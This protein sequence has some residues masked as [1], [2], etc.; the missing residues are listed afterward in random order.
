M[1]Y[2]LNSEE[3]LLIKI[4]KNDSPSFFGLIIRVVR[5]SKF[6]SKASTKKGIVR[7]G[8][9]GDDYVVDK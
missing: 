7:P 6:Q 3:Y 2:S 8:S 5:V 9:P 1:Q 4:L